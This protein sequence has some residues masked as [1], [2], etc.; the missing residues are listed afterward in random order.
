[1]RR[2]IGGRSAAANAC[3]GDPWLSINP[4]RSRRWRK[5]I[6]TWTA[7]QINLLGVSNITNST[8]P[9]VIDSSRSYVLT[10]IGLTSQCPDNRINQSNHCRPQYTKNSCK[11]ILS[12]E[13]P[14]YLVP[15]YPTCSTSLCYL[16]HACRSISE[17]EL[18]TPLLEAA[19]PRPLDDGASTAVLLNEKG[20]AP[21][22]RAMSCSPSCQCIASAV[23]HGIPISFAISN[24]ILDLNLRGAFWSAYSCFFSSRGSV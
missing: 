8:Y 19:A 6:W 16:P 10:G 5:Y 23:L 14:I 9:V 22:R 1:M 15:P 13:P 7:Y 24:H 4:V 11:P 21:A 3:I 18:R 20:I 17:T 12:P 2:T